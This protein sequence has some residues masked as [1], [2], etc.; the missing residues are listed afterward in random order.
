MS[1]AKPAIHTAIYWLEMASKQLADEADRVWL[2]AI[3]EELNEF[4]EM[5][6]SIPYS[7][8]AHALAD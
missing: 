3:V 2:D 4:M 7:G 8:D 5:A 1:D 6:E